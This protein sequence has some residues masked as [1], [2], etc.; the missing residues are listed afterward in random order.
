[1]MGN[2]WEWCGNWYEAYPTG[3]VTD[4]TGPASG[5]ILVVRGGGWTGNAVRCGAAFRGSYH[6]GNRGSSIRFRPALS[7]VR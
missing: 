4:P 5:S 6:L 3:I 1:M 7:A 2:L